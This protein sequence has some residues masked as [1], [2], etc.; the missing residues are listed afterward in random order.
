M[1]FFYCSIFIFFY[2]IFYPGLDPA[3][4]RWGGNAQAL[5]TQAGRY[6][7][8][9]HTDG[10]TLGIMDRIAHVDYYPNGGRNPQPGCWISTCSHSRAYRFFAASVRYNRFAGRQC[11]NMN[12]VSNNQCAG[13][14]LHM[15]NGIISKSGYV[16]FFLSSLYRL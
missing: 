10:G 1:I 6:V 14:T 13:S 15:G 7:E 4:P 3:G 2:F 11:S 5:N 8:A 9:I 16:T 12:Q